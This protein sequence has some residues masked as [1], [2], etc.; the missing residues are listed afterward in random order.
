MGL[1]V[2]IQTCKVASEFVEEAQCFLEGQQHTKEALR[3]GSI[4]DNIP[5]LQ[6]AAMKQT[7]L[8]SW[9]NH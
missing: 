5:C 9:L 1:P 2:L 3:I 4:I 7:T 6:L 8:D